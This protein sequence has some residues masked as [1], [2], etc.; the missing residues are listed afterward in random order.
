[1][2]RADGRQVRPHRRPREAGDDHREPHHRGAQGE[3]E[4]HR[5]EVFRGALTI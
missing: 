3:D 1:M 4:E 5:D 2:Q